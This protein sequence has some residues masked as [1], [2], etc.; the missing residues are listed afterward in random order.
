MRLSEEAFERAYET[1]RALGEETRFRIY[2]RLCLSGDPTS[3][4]DL[5]DAFS[6]HPN[7]IRQHLAR[8]EQAG[9]AT[10][11]P[12]REG[13]AGRPRRLYRAVADPL[14]GLGSRSV[15]ALVA[16]LQDALTDLPSERPVLVTLGE[17]WGRAWARR[18]KRE[19]GTPRTR[20]GRAEVLAGELAVWGWDPRTRQD[21]G[22]MH[23]ET[24]RCL[25]PDAS[26]RGC[27]LEEGLLAGLTEGLLNGR[28]ASIS[29]DG[30]R[31]EVTV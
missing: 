10:S 30:C 13:G 1:A 6:L 29:V 3:V 20:R 17:A 8:L 27:A 23:L 22:A 16:L 18:R 25:F 28:A 21:N 14:V 26:G 15:P 4:S 2:R 19:E 12:H 24:A 11:R 5:A 31:L 9:L 7:A